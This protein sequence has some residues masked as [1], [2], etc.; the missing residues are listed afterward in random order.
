MQILTGTRLRIIPK[1]PFDPTNE[2]ASSLGHCT[3]KK[4]IIS[5]NTMVRLILQ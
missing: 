5:T 3:A 2:A 4:Q 1:Q